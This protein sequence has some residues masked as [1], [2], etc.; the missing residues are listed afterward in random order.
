[1]EQLFPHFCFKRGNRLQGSGVYAKHMEKI[2]LL[3]ENVT[4]SWQRARFVRDNILVGEIKRIRRIS[5][6][7]LMK[8]DTVINTERKKR[9]VKLKLKRTEYA[10]GKIL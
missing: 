6:L 1:M 10:L 7:S 3:K 5:A 9:K 8:K 4:W 2:Y